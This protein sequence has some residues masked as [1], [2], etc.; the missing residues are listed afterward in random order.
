M[1]FHSTLANLSSGKSHLPLIW[2]LTLNSKYQEASKAG[3]LRLSLC[4]VSQEVFTSGVLQKIKVHALILLRGRFQCPI[5]SY[6]YRVLGSSVCLLW[7]EE[8]KKNISSYCC[9]RWNLQRGWFMV[10]F[11][12]H[13]IELNYF[14]GCIHEIPFFN[15]TAITTP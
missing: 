10:V 5:S 1:S 11:N 9:T 3:W 6:C 8:I 12:L 14:S 4:C 7:M 15:G 2:P 13:I